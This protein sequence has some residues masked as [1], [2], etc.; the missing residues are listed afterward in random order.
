MALSADGS[1]ALIGGNNDNSG[2]GAAWAFARSGTS[3]TQQGSKL[4]ASGETGQG[5]FGYSVALSADGS[6]ALIGGY[7]DNNVV[8]AAWVF[9]RS[10]TSWS[11]QGS[12]L[13]AGGE[14]GQVYF[15]S[16]AALSSDGSTAL[17]GGFYNSTGVGA[18]WVFTRSGTTWSQ[19]GSKLTASD[20]AGL[21]QFG[22]SVALSADGNTALIG[23]P[24]DSNAGAT[25][26]FTRSGTSWS[27]QGSKLT[28]SG[29]TGP[30]QFGYSV[31]LSADGSMVLIGG[32][33]DNN[34]VGATWVFTRSGASWSQQGL[35][36]TASD[37]TGQG[38]FGSSVALSADGGT[39]LIGGPLDNSTYAGVGVGAAWVFTR[40]GTSWSQQGSKLTPSDEAGGY[41]D[42]GGS[43]ALSA[44][45]STALIGGPLD[46]I[47]VGAAWVFIRSGTA[48]AQQG[49]KLTASDETGVGQFGHSVALSADGNTAL[50]G[51]P[52]DSIRMGYLGDGV[53]AEWVF[54]RSSTTWTQHGSKLTASDETGNGQF[55][56]SVAL[57]ADGNTA[58]IGG[59]LDNS[60]YTGGGLGAAWVFTR[61]GTS[62]SQ[63]G[64]KLTASDETG[65]YGNF[66]ASV[67]LSA[68]GSTAL[69]GGPVN[70]YGQGGAWVF[71]RSGASWG[72]QGS[73]LYPGAEGPFSFGSSVA[74]SSDGNTALIG[75]PSE[76][77]FNYPSGAVWVFANVAQQTLTV[78][79]NG[80][81]S[82]S[83]TSSPPGIDCGSTCQA[84]FTTGTKVT[85][86]ANPA[87]GSSFAG[88]SG[89]GCSGTG[90]CQVTVSSDQSVTAT[91]NVA[92]PTQHALTV[93]KNGAGSGSVTSSPPGID[94]GSTCQAQFTTGT[95]VTLSANPAPGSSFAGWSGGGCSGTGDCQVTV[96]SDQSVTA[97]FN[98][99]PPTQHALTVTKNGA[100]SGSVT[101]S[102]PGIDCGST[103]Q[104]QFTTG[105]K[106]TLSANPAPGSSFAGWS[107]GGCSGTGDCQ[108]TVSS[109]Q[110]V[111][112]TF[113]V[114]APPPA[115]PVL[116]GLVLS[117]RTS[118]ISGRLVKGHCVP[119]TSANHKQRRC[120]RPIKLRIAFKLSIAAQ[121]RMTIAQ[122]L[123]GRLVGGHCV[124]PTRA[125]QGHLGCTRSVLL[126]GVLT[127]SGSQGAGS[128][129][130]GGRI[131][132]R[133]LGS[134]S[135]R[136]T[137]IPRANGKVG[138][139][140]TIAFTITG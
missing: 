18:A 65:G 139:P 37:E 132:G 106:V 2:V 5:Q 45:G 64:S 40:S 77:Q 137:A 99:A 85:L 70:A 58:L 90:D 38:Q 17:I 113:N 125:N 67:A 53:G 41:G 46:N 33:N 30:G 1:T 109:D 7:M 71:T 93:T 50:V 97:T 34:G 10:G 60:S 49:S 61:A 9:T 6:T 81:G 116:S 135:Y 121:V 59:P 31:A 111:T 28:A 48:W 105:T 69:I 104:A 86:S 51:G 24:Y 83:V 102:P 68:D 44:D 80:A 130:F 134:G 25:W 127:A 89:G 95:K 91:F 84:Q 27:Q 110:S 131:G 72:Q 22:S 66:G 3:W 82:G 126:R 13:T 129:T 92:P 29:E 100:G 140:T 47:Y 73:R 98:V 79:K 88:W 11:Q 128:L 87:P 52:L 54:T 136:L 39:A 138:K 16:S 94:C 118:S 15:G 122:Q 76:G 119:A 20:E 23:G 117:P 62:W 26:V 35:K 78:T 107:G 108:V 114:S 12:K 124:K 55:G 43:V 123:P 19:Q 42:F 57:S 8:G 21:G 103:C 133:S 14:T 112:A 74:V 75:A 63:Q 96:S 101:S 120:T 36:L 56:S 115:A 32:P 4:T